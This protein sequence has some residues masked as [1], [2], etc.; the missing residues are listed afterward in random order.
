LK[1]CT[2]WFLI[3]FFLILVI[4]VFTG[5]SIYRYSFISSSVKADAAVVLGAAVWLGQPSPVYR[6]RIYHAI[7]LYFARRVSYI[8]FA[9][10]I[11]EGDALSEAEIGRDLAIARGVAPYHIYIDIVSTVTS[12][13]LKNALA[14]GNVNGLSTY[15]IVS[16]P[17]HMKRVMFIAKDI[18]MQAFPSPTPSSRYVSWKTQFPFL[19]KEI[20]FLLSY[21]VSSAVRNVFADL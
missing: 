9:G 10:G 18:G 11:G 4:T 5:L 6:E 1:H 8:I 15:I 2:K 20:Y 14:I 17:L 3:I 16:D 7:D 13:N 12:E 19:L 21:E